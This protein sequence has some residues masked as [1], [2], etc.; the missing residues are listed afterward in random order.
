MLL[1]TKLL[2][3][4]LPAGFLSRN[5]PLQALDDATAR[6]VCLVCAPAGYGKTTLLVDWLKQRRKQAAWLSLD[7]GENDPVAFWY[8]LCSA[9]GQL[10][11]RFINNVWPHFADTGEGTRPGVH[12]L[13]NELW[14]WSRSWAANDAHYLVIDDFH[15]L[16]DPGLLSSF[17]WFLDHLPNNLRIILVS[18][19]QP[20]LGLARRRLAGSY[21]MIS[22]AQLRFCREGTEELF[23]ERFNLELSA[24]QIQQILARTEGW[25]VALHLTGLAWQEQGHYGQLPEPARHEAQGLSNYLMNELFQRQPDAV[26]SFLVH[27]ARLPRFSAGLCSALLQREDSEAM[28]DYLVRHNLL[29]QA[30]DDRHEWFRL[31]DLFRDW[32]NS[33]PLPATQEQTLRQRAAR[34][35]ENQGYT[36]EAF[37]QWVA[38]SDW[39]SA[40]RLV[41]LHFLLWWQ[42][43]WL[44]RAER[45]LQQFP[46]AWL[47]ANPWLRYLEGFILFQR[48][49]LINA[50]QALREAEHCFSNHP[51]WA[52]EEEPLFPAGQSLPDVVRAEF[53]LH[54]ASLRAH[55]ARLGGDIQTAMALSEGLSDE[56]QFSDSPLLDWT[57]AGC[58]TDQ[59]YRMNLPLARDFGFRAI[60]QARRNQNASCQIV[61][62]IWLVTSLVHQGEHRDAMAWIDRTQEAIGPEWKNNVWAPNLYCQRALILREQNQLEAAADSLNQAFT[63]ATDE[64]M[65]QCL[66][67]FEFLRWH[68]ALNRGDFDTA[69]QAIEQIEYWHSRQDVQHWHYTVLEPDLMRALLRAAQGQIDTLLAWTH[70]FDPNLPDMPTWLDFARLAVWLRVQVDLGGDI[71]DPL[72]HFREQAKAGNVIT[73]QTKAALLYYRL[74]QQENRPSA[75]Q[76]MHQALWLSVQHDQLRTFLDDGPGLAS[77]LQDCLEDQGVAKEAGRILAAMGVNVPRQAEANDPLS[78]RER[79]VLALLESGM[80][81]PELARELGISLSTVKAHLRNIFVKLGVKN[82]TQAISRAGKFGFVC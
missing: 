30:L 25:A 44:P 54:M 32:L 1:A 38:L 22:E 67:Y 46:R 43:G 13:V 26:Q 50:A 59:F 70:H 9:L 47:A 16:S 28:V 74:A 6:Q 80:S 41:T 18:R 27:V 45:C 15:T 58:C 29:V 65:P 73:W 39:S 36:Y 23:A 62:L 48:G 77:G 52:P 35:L 5:R 69:E 14:A 68:I 19:T 55:I 61:S 75:R 11:A 21:Q 12:Q 24:D 7:A 60:H 71:A 66:V 51:Y 72:S 2:R 3:P 31:H 33:M 40:A 10:N 56:A 34:W 37:E 78:D 76:F 42:Q 49:E 17:D 8:A 20:D 63:M 79:Q 82:R 53:P 4:G 81:N 57:L 64:L